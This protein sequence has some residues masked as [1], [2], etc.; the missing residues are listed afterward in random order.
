ML[1][2]ISEFTLGRPE[3]N[4]NA[5]GG[6]QHRP[7]Q[8]SQPHPLTVAEIQHLRSVASSGYCP[9]PWPITRAV[10]ARRMQEVGNRS[11]ENGYTRFLFSLSYGPPTHT[12][13]TLCA[14]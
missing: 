12:R 5:D 14:F 9:V 6:E 11:L 10:V 7:P 8:P 4:A 1:L 2:L 13:V 3:M